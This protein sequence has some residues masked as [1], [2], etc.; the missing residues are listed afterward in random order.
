MQNSSSQN[1]PGG[2]AMPK[3]SEPSILGGSF[4]KKSDQIMSEP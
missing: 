4:R 3:I 1:L 2:P